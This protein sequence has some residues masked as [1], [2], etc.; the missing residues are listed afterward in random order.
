V[1]DRIPISPDL[2]KDFV[3][4]SHGRLDKVREL[5]KEEPG[6][7]RASMDWGEGD[8]ESGLEAAGHVGNKDIAQLLLDNDAP[9]TVFCA[10]ML[11][12]TNL[13]KAFLGSDPDISRRPGVHKISLMYHVA[14]SGKVEIAELF[15]SPPGCDEALH[16]SIRFG[17]T[18][19]VAWLL[20]NGA[21]DV[22][23]LNFQEKTPL[24]AALEGEHEKI[25][26]LLRA[27]GAHE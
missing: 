4:A 13:I 3:L 22:N 8:W 15:S 25:A 26:D 21:N 18:E 23:I 17:H 16:A 24:A 19:M 20:D 14:L 10:A 6:L 1:S 2:V 27:N 11:G 9:M 12:E 7:V 5:Q